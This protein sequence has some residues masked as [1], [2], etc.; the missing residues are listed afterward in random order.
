MDIEAKMQ[1]VNRKD[2]IAVGDVTLD[3][4]ITLHQVK[5]LKLGEKTTVALPRR[6]T[7]E[8]WKNIVT[9]LAPE[10]KAEIEKN[11]LEAVWKEAKRSV[12]QLSWEVHVHL[13]EG[14][15][16]LKG[17]ASIL[18]PEIF[19]LTGIQ[20]K[21]NGKKLQV[22]YPYGFIGTQMIS[23]AGPTDLFSKDQLDWQILE[24]YQEEERIHKEEKRKST[25]Q[26]RCHL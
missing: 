1:I 19:E 7:P 2:L 5:V 10:L 25:E 18:Y 3:N 6:K 4:K 22:V 20:I 26:G 16:G 21:E 14:K 11:V 8:G 24:K 15:N 23:L 9:L 17:Y 12:P 13:Y